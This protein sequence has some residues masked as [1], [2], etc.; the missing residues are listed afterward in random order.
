MCGLRMLAS[1][2]CVVAIISSMWRVVYGYILVIVLARG[3]LGLLI[4]ICA[5]C[6]RNF[7]VLYGRKFFFIILAWGLAFLFY[8]MGVTVGVFMVSSIYHTTNLFT[9]GLFILFLC[10][11]LFSILVLVQIN[12]PSRKA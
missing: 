6:H 3:V 7:E 5:L 8:E 4:Y 11:L 12:S 9:F 1:V 10:G 2:L